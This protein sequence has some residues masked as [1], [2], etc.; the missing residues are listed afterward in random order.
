MTGT[1]LRARREALGIGR[2]YMAR[3]ADG[4]LPLNTQ[5]YLEDPDNLATLNPVQAAVAEKILSELEKKW[6]EELL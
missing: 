2:Y 5:E 4:A 3:K 6:R 1:E